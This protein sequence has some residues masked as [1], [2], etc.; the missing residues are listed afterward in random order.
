MIG[1]FV[2]KEELEKQLQEHIPL[3][4]IASSFDITINCVYKLIQKYNLTALYKESKK[5]THE[6]LKILGLQASQLYIE[7]IIEKL[8]RSCDVVLSKQEVQF[9]I[10]LLKADD[11]ASKDDDKEKLLKE[12][13]NAGI[14]LNYIVPNDPND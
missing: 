6:V 3:Y 14:T 8:K 4:Q 1:S 5:N 2:K 9:I 11:F 7:K 12:L 13:A 10:E